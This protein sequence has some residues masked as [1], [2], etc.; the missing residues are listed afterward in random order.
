VTVTLNDVNEAPV[1]V[2]QSFQVIA[3]S[4]A[5]TLVGTVLA[6]DPDAGQELSYTITAGNASGAFAL[7]GTSG[8]ITVADTGALGTASSFT[9]TVRATDSATPALSASAVVTITVTS[10][11]SAPVEWFRRVNL[12]GVA[13]CPRDQQRSGKHNPAYRRDRN[14]G[15]YWFVHDS[16]NV[17]GYIAVTS[18]RSYI[19]QAPVRM[20]E[21]PKRAIRCVMCSAHMSC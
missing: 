17:F 8:R 4:S 18:R 9:L 7:D 11:N 21:T 16:P 20:S 5:G 10:G 13:G 15:Q 12:G 3:N 2:D 14:R 19:I 6:S 1:I